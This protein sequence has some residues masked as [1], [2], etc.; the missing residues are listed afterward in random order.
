MLDPVSSSTDVV[1]SGDAAGGAAVTQQGSDKT[2]GFVLEHLMYSSDGFNSDFH[3]RHKG[4]YRPVTL[5][6]T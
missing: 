6:S 5:A 2:F 4:Y 3:L 1:S